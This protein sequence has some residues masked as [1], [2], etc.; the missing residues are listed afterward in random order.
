MGDLEHVTT[1]ICTERMKGLETRIDKVEVIT[2]EVHKLAVS[3]ERLSV[4]IENM[5]KDQAAH[6]K[7]IGVLEARDSEMWR[8]FIK[9][10]ITATVGVIVGYVMRNVGF[11]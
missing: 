9:Y 8:Y 3:V 6:E 1:T 10:I 7:R 4:S 5:V 2:E 11:D